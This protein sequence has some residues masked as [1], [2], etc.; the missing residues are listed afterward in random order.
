[1]L[2]NREFCAYVVIRAWVYNCFTFVLDKKQKIFVKNT[3]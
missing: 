3:V 1:M 2:L